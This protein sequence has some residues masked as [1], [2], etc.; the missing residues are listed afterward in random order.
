M[1]LCNNTIRFAFNWFTTMAAR[2]HMHILKYHMD[3]KTTVTG[4]VS[5]NSVYTSY[6]YSLLLL[7]TVTCTII[8]YFFMIYT[9]A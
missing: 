9:V 8:S 4:A 7:Q 5:I 3:F 1:I 2:C 6:E